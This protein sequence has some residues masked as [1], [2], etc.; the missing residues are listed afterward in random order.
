M[1]RQAV[2][3]RTDWCGELRSTDVGR[4]A[5][6]CG[7]VARKREH[8]QHLAFIDVRDRTGIVQC[9]VDQSVDLRSEYVVRVTGTLSMR[10]E[11]TINLHIPTGEIELSD[12]IVEILNEAEPP[13]FSLEE[14]SDAD[15]AIRLKY[16]FVDIR[17]EK[18]RNHLELRSTVNAALRNSMI[19][20]GFT[21]VETPMLW[22]PT[23]EGAR[24]FAVPSRLQ[25]GK[26]YVLPQSPQIAKQLLMV[27]GM[28]RYF[29]LA[30]CMRDEDLRADRQFEF[31]QLDIEASFV[32]MEEVLAFIEKAVVDASEAAL[33]SRP[34]AP[35]R[36]TW[37]E[38][39]D[40]FGTDKPDLRFGMELVDLG[41]ALVATEFN[42][43]KAESVKAILVPGG[44]ELP[45]S[46]LD[47]LIDRSKTL[48]AKGLVWMK[49]VSADSGLDVESPTSKYLSQ[50]EKDAVIS[51]CGGKVGD[52]VLI[53]A[54]EHD[55]VCRVLGQLRVE[56]GRPAAGDG[57]LA[58]AW[59]VE[60]PMFDGFDE[61]G[62]PIAA[63]HPF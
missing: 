40:R 7:W 2:G 31:T 11:G 46:R 59:V 28:D 27:A 1:S 49:V 34:A 62:N 15:E 24:E 38:A 20:Q 54:G 47:A 43:F 17:R 48:G 13:P 18:M 21:E 50:P 33:G 42:A 32:G 45:R 9:V 52:L 26:F 58:F 51:N 56:L 22:T 19:E 37:A 44:S 39:M 23:P 60:F 57:G 4:Q 41:E 10:P 61:A 35:V 63:H 3:M 30:R 14:W 5:S 53:V 29:Q 36:M 55:M 8:S 16:R 12:C 6:I 25:Q